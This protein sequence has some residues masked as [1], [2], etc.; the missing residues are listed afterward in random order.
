MKYFKNQPTFRI[1]CFTFV[2]A[3]LLPIIFNEKGVLHVCPNVIYTDF[4]DSFFK[5]YTE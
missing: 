5:Y 2:V 1:P 3:L 4:S